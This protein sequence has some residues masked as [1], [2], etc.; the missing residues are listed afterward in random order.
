M[1]K[2]GIILFLLTLIGTACTDLDEQL[3]DKLPED[4]YPESDAQI[5]SMSVDAYKQMQ[6]LCDDEGWWFWAQEVTSD[7]LVFPTRDADWDDGGKWRVMYQHTWNNDVEGVNRMWEKLFSGV[8]RSNQILDMLRQLPSTEAIEA[9]IKEVEVI[10]SFFYYL[11]IDNYGDA[12][13][14][15]SF[16]GVPAQP[17]KNYRAAIFD[18]LTTVVENNL[19]AL[20]PINNKY[21]ATRNFAFALLA[22]LYLNAEVYTGTPQ[23]EKAKQYTDSIIASPFYSLDLTVTAP[24]A[25]NNESNG[26]IIFSIPYDEDDYQGFRIHM[27]TLHYQSN[28]TYDMT[29]GPWNGCAVTN[30]HFSTYADT[31]LRKDAYFMYGP[32]YD[33]NGQPIIESVT[34]AP[35]NLNPIIPA[36]RMDATFTPTEIRTSGARIKKYE[37]KK[38]AKE[39]LSN[40]FPLFRLSDFYLIKAEVEIRLGNDGDEWIN[41]IRRR[42]NVSEFD[43]ATLDDVLAE[44]GRELFAEGQRR[45]DLI[46]Y[47]KYTK[48]WWA[49]GDAQGGTSNDPAVQTFPIPKWATDA[50]PNLLADPQ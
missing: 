26:E 33:S 4:V 2:F 44:R 42:A 15:S 8:T 45:Q 18:S 20:K 24:F 34:G 17:F 21:M 6:P 25:T 31:D 22:K 9:K 36:L 38:G 29:V 10:R 39:N 49:K 28:L 43:G 3:Y 12:P 14:L 37:I 7:E 48:A 35:L 16:S 13:Y 46:R 1:K 47:G 23:W 30:Q 41:Y 11:I 5:A 27:R 32:Q 40:D 19:S 50:N